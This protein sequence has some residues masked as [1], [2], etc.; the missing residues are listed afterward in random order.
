M[1]LVHTFGHG[2]SLETPLSLDKVMEL[3][4]Q[5]Q[6]SQADLQGEVSSRLRDVDKKF[7]TI[8][9]KFDTMKGHL[10]RVEGKITVY[11]DSKRSVGS[12]TSA[13]S[14]VSFGSDAPANSFISNA[15]GTSTPSPLVFA[16]ER[17][18][19]DSRLT[20]I[21]SQMGQFQEQLQEVNEGMV[22]LV[23]TM[24]KDKPDTVLGIMRK[25]SVSHKSLEDWHPHYILY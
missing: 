9:K 5:I 16:I 12:D 21:S 4:N 13:K 6:Q 14:L 19:D 20:N 23:D 25:L 24:T 11:F 22:M 1:S 15:S 3:L 7:D 10:D 17:T 2:T 8:D 18:S